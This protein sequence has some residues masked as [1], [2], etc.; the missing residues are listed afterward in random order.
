MR[1]VICL[2]LIY[3]FSASVGQHFL[4]PSVVSLSLLPLVFSFGHVLYLRSNGRSC[5]GIARILIAQITELFQ[6]KSQ[7]GCIGQLSIESSVSLQRQVAFNHY[8]YFRPECRR[9]GEPLIRLVHAELIVE[10]LLAILDAA[11]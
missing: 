11:S 6:G 8:F 7:R 1:G 9:P 5:R 2:S 4:F 3:I 10:S